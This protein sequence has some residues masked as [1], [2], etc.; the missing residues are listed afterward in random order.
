MMRVIPAPVPASFEAKVRA[1]GILAMHE[2]IGASPPVA[3]T[4]GK[5]CARAKI[6]PGAPIK[7][8]EDLR[9]DDFPN[10]W[11][12][13]LADLFAAYG[14]VC[15]YCCFYIHPV[16]GAR[17]VDHMI[18]KSETWDQ[19]YEWRNYRLS[20]GRLNARKNDY[21][22]VLDP[23]DVQDDWFEME[24][25]G[26]QLKPR[27]GLAPP[28]RERIVATIERLKLNDTT[29]C[30][31]RE[32]DYDDYRNNDISRAKLKRE[33]PLVA[34]EVTRAGKLRRDDR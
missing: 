27:A 10:Y 32:S 9:P 29:M 16:T 7:R 13:A 2:R 4:A 20:A 19:V 21:Q 11:V 1:P 3:R 17:S 23:F 18:P 15:R 22:D 12:R 24:F 8:L 30:E 25:V 14:R 31:A 6:A 26:F 33:S 34:R 28:T 5:V